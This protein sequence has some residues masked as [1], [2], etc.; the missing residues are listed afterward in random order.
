MLVLLRERRGVPV[1]LL[2]VHND[3]DREFRG[4]TVPP[5]DVRNPGQLGI[6][7]KV[8]EIPH[9]KVYGPSFMTSNGFSILRPAPPQVQVPLHTTD[10]AVEFLGACFQLW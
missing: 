10:S 2:E 9:S 3:F 1:T 4:N 5:F 7:E 8:H 6:A